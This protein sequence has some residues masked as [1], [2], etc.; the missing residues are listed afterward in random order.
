MFKSMDADD[1]EEAGDGYSDL[2][3]E[4]MHKLR[5]ARRNKRRMIQEI[6]QEL[7]RSILTLFMMGL[8]LSLSPRLAAVMRVGWPAGGLLEAPVAQSP[9]A[10]AYHLLTA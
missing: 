10:V 3:G 9:L 7:L 4:I 8:P 1:W 2:L 5:V 6:E